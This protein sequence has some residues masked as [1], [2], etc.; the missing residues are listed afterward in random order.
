MSR[1]ATVSQEKLQRI[2]IEGDAQILVSEAD[3]LG[4]QLARN[5]ATSQIR[6]I[7]GTVRQIEMN[8]HEEADADE[9]S[10]Q[11]ILLKPKLLYRASKENRRNR[12]EALQA[13][14]TVLNSSIDMV[15]TDR[16]RFGHFVE[17]FEAILAYH[18]Y[19]GGRDN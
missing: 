13:L 3:K 18:K 17:F 11:L 19:H 2:I 12:R 8:W 6:A 4:K 7:F 1:Q 15:E 14:A 16:E 9:H 5:M 10:R